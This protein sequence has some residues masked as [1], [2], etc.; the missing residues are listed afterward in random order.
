MRTFDEVVDLSVCD[1]TCIVRILNLCTLER[2]Q[3]IHSKL[4]RAANVIIS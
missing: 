2:V 4:D 3:H 1:M